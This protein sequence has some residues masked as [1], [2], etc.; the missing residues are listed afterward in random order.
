M[1]PMHSPTPP[2][3]PLAAIMIVTAAVGSP[4]TVKAMRKC[5]ERLIA[6][7]A[8]LEAQGGRSNVVPLA[9]VSTL[10]ERSKAASEALTVIRSVCDGCRQSQRFQTCQGVPSTDVTAALAEALAPR[11][12]G[13]GASKRDR[14][15][16]AVT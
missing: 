2:T 8:R 10:A 16:S 11:H 4:K 3:R 9:Y 12:A 7:M 6:Q 1:T 5:R 15:T 14:V 13:C